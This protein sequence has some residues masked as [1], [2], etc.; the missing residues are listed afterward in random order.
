MVSGLRSHGGLM[1]SELMNINSADLRCG[2]WSQITAAGDGK[3][4][5]RTLAEQGVTPLRLVGPQGI[6]RTESLT[7]SAE[8]RCRNSLPPALD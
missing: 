3:Q 6:T 1:R 8:N 7:I 5:H 4:S 2:R